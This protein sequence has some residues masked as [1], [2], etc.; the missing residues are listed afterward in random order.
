VHRNQTVRQAFA[1]DSQ[2]QAKVQM[3]ST[4]SPSFRE[5]ATGRGAGWRLKH[6]CSEFLRNT[7]PRLWHRLKYWQYLQTGE[8]EIHHLAGLVDPKR[9]AV[10]AGVYLG[11]YSRKLSELTDAVF[12]FEPHED[13]YAAAIRY[14]PQRVQLRQM[15]LSDQDGSVTLRVPVTP[16]DIGQTALS[17]CSDTNDLG[18]LPSRSITV[19][20]RRLDSLNLPPVG[21][22]KIDVEGYEEFV[23]RGA[24]G[25]LQ[26]D[27]PNLL[28]E[29]EERHNKAGY[30]R[31]CTVLGD[32]GYRPFYLQNDKFHQLE[33]GFDIQTLQSE[34]SRYT[35]NF[36]FLPS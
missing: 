35:N 22:I 17:T 11:F 19:P 28:I 21:F 24:M 27:K 30:A 10:D 23:I 13:T 31:I 16:V 12:G 1:F 18:G 9:A 3:S 6:R 2:D 7:D 25:L 36:F 20:R 4:P 15:A 29:I 33:P 14:L 26:R 34:P 5:H 32:L 8:N